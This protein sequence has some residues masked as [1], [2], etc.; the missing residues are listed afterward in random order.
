M[1]LDLSG[2]R[3]IDGIRIVETTRCPRKKIIE[4]EI[5]GER[6]R[7]R[8]REYYSKATWFELRKTFSF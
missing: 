5:E 8:E 6:E 7:E 1:Y 2:E 3:H 4:R